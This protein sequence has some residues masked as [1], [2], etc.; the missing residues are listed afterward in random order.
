[1]HELA[2][3]QALIQQ[4]EEALRAKSVQ[5]VTTVT[6][7]VGKLAGVDPDCLQF[8]FPLAA[9]GTIAEG[10]ELIVEPVPAAVRCRTCGQTTTTDVPLF[11]CAACG[12]TE[13]ELASGRELLLR[14]VE[15]DTG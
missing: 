8:A 12:G 5:R 15:I 9:E 1:M 10:A 2:V 14:S 13:V 6:I 11:A 4:V 3:A 7:A